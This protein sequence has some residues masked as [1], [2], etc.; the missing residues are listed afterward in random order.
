MALLEALQQIRWHS[1]AVVKAQGGVLPLGNAE[2]KGGFV[3]AAAVEVLLLLYRWEGNSGCCATAQKM[4]S[5]LC[6]GGR[7]RS[8]LGIIREEVAKLCA[9]ADGQQPVS[10]SGTEIVS[11]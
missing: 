10:T 11:Q 2:P 8:V 3:H 9:E 5:Q 1:V 6:R 7:G 4:A